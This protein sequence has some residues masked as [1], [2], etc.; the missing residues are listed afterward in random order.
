MIQDE[1]GLYE[2]TMALW[3][4][5]FEPEDVSQPFTV[6]YGDADDII[7]PEMPRRV[8]DRLPDATA[9]PWPGAGHYGFVDTD[10]WRDF[11]RFRC[12]IVASQH[13]LGGGRRR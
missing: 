3:R 10:R 1:E 4:W 5:G 2:L 13:I 6:F 12:L 8:A 9:V 11:L 7:S